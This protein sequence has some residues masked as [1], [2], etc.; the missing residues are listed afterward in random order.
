M[1]SWVHFTENGFRTLNT[2]SNSPVLD[3]T[4][5]Q[6]ADFNLERGISAHRG[7]VVAGHGNSIL[8]GSA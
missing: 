3:I 8:N 1:G 2:R 4:A 5:V 6:V 7:V